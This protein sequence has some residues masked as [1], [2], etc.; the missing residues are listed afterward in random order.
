MP[1]LRAQRR[2]IYP[3]TALSAQTVTSQ[4]EKATV[5]RGVRL[6]VYCSV[7]T[8]GGGVDSISLCA[9]PPNGSG[10]PVVLAG[11]NKANMLAQTGTLVFDFY[12][13]QSNSGFAGTGLTLTVGTAY[14]SAAITLPMQWAVQIT[15]GAA[16]SA[17]VAIDTEILP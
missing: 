4:T 3:S 9:L 1:D 11:F 17:T 16:N 8:A 15:L 13:G 14:G 10:T 6:Y 12:P 5:G 2:N 7:P